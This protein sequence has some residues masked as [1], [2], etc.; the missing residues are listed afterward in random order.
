M[1]NEVQMK[2]YLLILILLLCLPI[3]AQTGPGSIQPSAIRTIQDAAV[4]NGNGTTFQSRTYGAVLFDIALTGTATVNFEG[5]IDSSGTWRAL[6]GYNQA[7]TASATT[8]TA[9]GLWFV[10][11]PGCE[12]V[13]ARISGV[14][15]TVAVTVIVR[16]VPSTADAGRPKGVL[17]ET[18]PIVA[19]I[20]GL[21]KS[22]AGV[23][24]AAVA[25]TDY[26]APNGSGTALV[27]PGLLSIASGKT[28]TA[29]NTL[30][31]TATDGS[32]LAIGGGGALG[33][34]AYTSTAYAPLASPTFTGTVIIPKSVNTPVVITFNATLPTDASLGNNY[35]CTL[36]N[37]FTLQNPT[38]ATDGQVINYELIQ[39]GTGSRIITYD[40]NFAFSTDL[41][42]CVLT[43]TASKRDFIS[44]VYNSGTGK[45]Y[46]RACNRGF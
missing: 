11:A 33:S 7:S 2:K 1:R 15:G 39:D 8:T 26:L 13:R 4:A 32:T 17:A 38:N 14:S 41:P 20:S 35:R 10:P 44:A 12:F 9:A 27:F 34:N 40:S 19:A 45:F 29:S 43:T 21:V 46:V 37:N 36:T 23:I 18:D 5:Q 28:L 3:R 25:G 24:A 22:T 31:L 42:T 16:G 30:T 6:I